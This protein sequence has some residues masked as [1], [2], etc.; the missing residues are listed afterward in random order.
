MENYI[1]KFVVVLV[2]VIL[3]LPLAYLF[4]V[5]DT[6]KIYGV[7]PKGELPSLQERSF[8]KREFQQDFESWWTSH[9]GFRKLALKTKNTLYDLANFNKI[10]A[11]FNRILIES[12]NKYLISKEGINLLY[13][14][15][16]L[17]NKATLAPKLNKLVKTLQADERQVL[18]VLGSTNADVYEDEI[19]DRFKFFAHRKFDVYRW[20]EDL[21]KE[22]N[23]PYLN[24]VP[25]MKDMA[26]KEGYEPYARTGS[27]WSAYGAARV[28]Q[29]IL[30]KLGLSVPPIK[31]ITVGEQTPFGERDF[32]NLINTFIPYLPDEKFLQ[33]TLAA[34]PRQIEKKF[35]LIGDSYTR[36]FV[37][38]A[39]KD[40]I[41]DGS[42]ILHIV[43][44]LMTEN[45][46]PNFF[47][48]KDIYLFINF[49]PN[50]NGP[51]ASMFRNIDTILRKMPTYFAHGWLRD[52]KG[53]FVSTDKSRIVIPNVDKN[54]VK[55]QFAL[56]TGGGYTK[57]IING[58]TIPLD[59]PRIDVILPGNS[60]DKKYRY[61][62]TFQSEK[63]VTIVGISVQHLPRKKVVPPK[64][65]F[66][67]GTLPRHAF[68]PSFAEN[69]GRW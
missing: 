26:K 12:D 69:R 53:G 32:A 55:L 59:K 15:P 34:P 30:R 2:F 39:K 66:A 62:V 51:N 60:V 40:K 31:E 64:I 9:F 50:W 4:G 25:L 41:V 44:H 36:A 52:E 7:E 23:I 48:G 54:D 16:C 38:T 14:N 18:F 5:K 49:G 29:E 8:L 46:V 65:N 67:D 27:H 47:N 63:P 10:H 61:M 24:T 35:V 43:N 37:I 17:H 19:P 11:G 20:W 1:K 57:M 56:H 28:T 13:N 6:T 22:L 33:V 45:E 68:R 58:K 42:H 21:L 3:F